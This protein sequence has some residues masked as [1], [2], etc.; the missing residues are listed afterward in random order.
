MDNKLYSF[1]LNIPFPSAIYEGTPPY[2]K[3]FTNKEFDKEQDKYAIITDKILS[4]MFV[5][6]Y[7]IYIDV[8]NY[9]GVMY[10]IHAKIAKLE[11]GNYMIN[12]TSLKTSLVKSISKDEFNSFQYDIKT[13]ELQ[14]TYASNIT[15]TVEKSTTYNYPESLRESE[16]FFK[17]DVEFYISTFNS[18]IYDKVDLETKIDIRL[19]KKYNY[20]SNTISLSKIFN[21]EGKLISIIGASENTQMTVENK[22]KY[23]TLRN[24]LENN[25]DGDENNLSALVVNIS[26]N[27]LIDTYGRLKKYSRFKGIKINKLYDLFIKTSMLTADQ[28]IY[29][30]DDILREY[31]DDNS[32][33]T[34]TISFVSQNSAMDLCLRY[35]T[36]RDVLSGDIICFI[37]VKDTTVNNILK[38]ITEYINKNIYTEIIYLDVNTEFYYLFNKI[39]KTL[40]FDRSLNSSIFNTSFILNEKYTKEDKLLNFFNLGKL[41]DKLNQKKP[42]TISSMVIDKDGVEKNFILTADYITSDKIIILIMD[43]SDIMALEKEKERTLKTAL[44]EAEIANLSKLT[45]LNNM[46]HDIRT[47]LTTVLNTTD[48]ALSEIEDEAS[49]SYFNDIKSSGNYLL[50][51][52]DDVLQMSRLQSNKVKSTK[53]IDT[54]KNLTDSVIKIVKPLSDEKNIDLILDFNFNDATT[55]NFDEIHTKQILINILTN[56]IKYTDFGFVKWSLSLTEENHVILLNNII[57][58]SGIG[59]NDYNF[60]NIFES[61]VRESD[62]ENTKP[63]TGLGLAITKNLVNL[64]KGTIQVQSIKSKG[65]SFTVKIPIDFSKKIDSIKEIY[66]D[67]SRLNNKK[68]LIAE[69]NKINSIILTKVLSKYNL[70]CTVAINGLDAINKY[71][72]SFDFVLMDI[73]MPIMNGLEATKGILNKSNK[74]IPIIALSANAFEEDIEASLE[75]G[76]KEHLT[77]PIKTDNLINVLLKYSK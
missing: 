54:L 56:A 46:S 52:I 57:E 55:I 74:D 64:L 7:S 75:C 5:S 59:I 51:I 16:H 48:L 71:D 63:G 14:K 4:H 33:L 61:F 73:R 65:S 11:D 50:N 13:K 34:C 66:V 35:E 20:I 2:K 1:L 27:K 42:Y 3:I 72:D 40:I 70:K 36:V 53:K 41:K 43:N 17:D 12:F 44:K 68:V 29:K 22:N 19:G 23:N 39:S 9:K 28:K 32:L 26:Q 25:R 37:F 76:M 31:L 38:N 77:K 8:L 47:P 15:S 69:D 49:L 67:V 60:E 10:Y 24:R 18:F 45:F 30:R 21:T 62:V 58:D 6:G